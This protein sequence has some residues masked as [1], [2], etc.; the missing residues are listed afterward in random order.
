M[1]ELASIQPLFDWIKINPAWAG[2]F[3]FLIAMSES[4]LVIGLVVPGTILMFGVGTLVGAGILGLWETFLWAFLGAIIGD[5]VSFWI[6]YFFSD[7]VTRLWPF[8][9]KPELLQK[10]QAFFLKHGGKSILFG[11]FVGPVRPIIPAVAGMM[12][13]SPWKF[14]FVNIASATGWAPANLLPGIVFGT[15]LGLASQVTT[16]LAI[17]LVALSVLA[18]LGYFL[19]KHF[20]LFVDPRAHMW[21]LEVYG[22]SLRHPVIGRLTKQV[23]DP[24][25]P[26]T[27]ALLWWALFLILGCRSGIYASPTFRVD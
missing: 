17:L 21:L 14:T 9:K 19:I 20:V 1:F 7:H 12:K 5:G 15:S 3:V 4:L 27:S 16:H 18:L 23:L 6:G 10:A 26:P 11:R 22:W 2:L 25:Y 8:K 24:K 13:M